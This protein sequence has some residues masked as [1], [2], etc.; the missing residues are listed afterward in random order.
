MPHMKKK[1]VKRPPLLT[2]DMFI[3]ASTPKVVTSECEAP[4]VTVSSEEPTRAMVL[5]AVAAEIDQDDD[6]NPLPPPR[7]REE[8][9]IRESTLRQAARQ[10]DREHGLRK[11]ERRYK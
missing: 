4:I 1:K 8:R 3:A 9:R 2:A 10:W 5:A 7:N 6:G 11:R